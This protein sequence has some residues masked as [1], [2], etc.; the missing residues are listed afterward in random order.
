MTDHQLFVRPPAL[1][2]LSAV[3]IGGVFYIAG[4]NIES[5]EAREPTQPG[6]ITVSGEGKV[7]LPPDIARLSFGVSTGR[8]PS[9]KMAGESLAKTVNAVLNAVKN[10]GIQEKDIKTAS[11]S[12]Y[13]EFDYD[14][15]IQLPRGFRA[16]ESITVTVRDL[17]KA[18]EIL[19]LAIAAG[20][21]ESSGVEFTVEN[22]EEERAKARQEAIVEA[23]KKANLLAGQLGVSLGRI[24]NFSEGTGNYPQP[25]MMERAM[26]KGAMDIADSIPIES[27]EQEIRVTVSL[28]YELR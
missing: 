14:D 21:N 19:S 12:L 5:R 22:P 7:S 9:S 25:M 4:K 1:L 24:V 28:T 10:A 27:G 26:M 6:T 16:S 2:I 23:K 18:G 15:G 13:P 8:L 3:I 20:A 17:D 11:V